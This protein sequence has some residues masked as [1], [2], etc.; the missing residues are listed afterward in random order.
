MSNL[1][2]VYEAR[3]AMDVAA[4]CL[5]ERIQ[6]GVPGRPAMPMLPARRCPYPSFKRPYESASW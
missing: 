4:G 5:A 2:P 1:R 6:G 3:A